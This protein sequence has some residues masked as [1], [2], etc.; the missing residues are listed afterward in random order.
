MDG[1]VID[2]RSVEIGGVSEIRGFKMLSHQNTNSLLPF[3]QKETKG[4]ILLN[5]SIR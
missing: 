1:S 5:N 2:G 3:P 4:I